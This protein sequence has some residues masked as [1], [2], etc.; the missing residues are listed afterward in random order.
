MFGCRA[1]GYLPLLARCPKRERLRLDQ[2]LM[3]ELRRSGS[4]SARIYFQAEVSCLWE[5][6][7]SAAEQLRNRGRRRHE[8]FSWPSSQRCPAC[9]RATVVHLGGGTGA[10]QCPPSKQV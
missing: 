8:G 1:V 7:N 10:N 4:A 3:F 5:R 6:I 2:E 9:L